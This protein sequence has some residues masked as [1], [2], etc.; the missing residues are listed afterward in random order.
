MWFQIVRSDSI[1]AQNFYVP[2]PKV[3]ESITILR[4]TAADFADVQ[5]QD[6]RSDTPFGRKRR[7]GP[8]RN[9]DRTVLSADR[10][11]IASRTVRPARVMTLLATRPLH[12]AAGSGLPMGTPVIRTSAGERQRRIVAYFGYWMHH[13]TMHVCLRRA[14]GER[15][16]LSQ[17]PMTSTAVAF[18]SNAASPAHTRV[19][20]AQ[21]ATIGTV[22]A[23][24]RCFAPAQTVACRFNH[25]E[26]TRSIAHR[27]ADCAHATPLS[28]R[29][30]VRDALGLVGH[31]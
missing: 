5:A 31:S 1:H 18:V 26:V 30:K 9:A 23:V 13:L 11:F 19:A 16:C 24:T 10:P 15:R 12:S 29:K 22:S 27:L 20:F 7:A 25:H 14:G 2:K 21:N 4:K 28:F 3:I 8:K 17:L 6:C